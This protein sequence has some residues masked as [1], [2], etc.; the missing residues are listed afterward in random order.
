MD[1]ADNWLT[2]CA[3]NWL[4][5]CKEKDKFKLYTVQLMVLIVSFQNPKEHKYCNN[6]HRLFFYFQRYVV[7]SFFV[8]VR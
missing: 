6:N 1:A 4:T 3:D 2:V 7:L 8:G 5:V